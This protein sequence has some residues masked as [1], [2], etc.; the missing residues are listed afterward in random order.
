[1]LPIHA[2]LE[3][4]KAALSSGNTAVLASGLEPGMRVVA[5]GVHVLSPGQKVLIYEE[6]VPQ[7]QQGRALAAPESIVSTPDNTPAAP[8]AKE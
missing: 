7:T 8:A 6:K 3:P 1:M 5:T 4:L 2:V